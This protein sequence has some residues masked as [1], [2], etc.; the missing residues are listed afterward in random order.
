MWSD[1]SK[2]TSIPTLFNYFL[3]LL[4]AISPFIG[5]LTRTLLDVHFNFATVVVCLVS[6][7][8]I[9]LDKL[10]FKLPGYTILLA[11]FMLYTIVSDLVIVEDKFD[12]KYVYSNLILGSLLIFVIIENTQISHTFFKMLFYVNHAVL[13]IAFVV[14]IIQQLYD[15]LF[16]VNPV[17][18]NFLESRDYANTR[19]PSIYSWIHATNAVG[20]CFIPILGLTIAHHL[21]HKTKGV[22]YLY[23]IGIVVAFISKSRFIMLNYLLLLALIPIYKG[24]TLGT[25]LRYFIFFIIF[26]LSI[27]YGSKTVGIDTDRIINERILERNRGGILEGSASSRFLAFEI[28]NRLYFEHPIFGKGTFHD[29]DT[30]V[31]QD[32]ELVNMLRGR[33]SMIHVG[34]LSLFYYYGI[35]G[36]IIYLAFLFML[37]R[38]SY[39]K[40]KKNNSWGPFFSVIQF[41]LINLT[42]VVFNIF[43]MGMIISFIYQ[44]YYSQ[45]S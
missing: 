17:Y 44:K 6:V 31:S 2:Q 42:G 13:L 7:Y 16:F 11:I 41:I 15:P 30:E 22:F 34:Y 4:I 40:S 32:Y 33:S 5:Y 35:I 25:S 12:L 21:K 18:H 19:F 20:L 8:L 36:G 9:F 39:I 24:F 10:S 1:N 37:T 27:Y 23:F 29:T 3:F 45:G 14:I 38:R 26:I 43:F 28:F